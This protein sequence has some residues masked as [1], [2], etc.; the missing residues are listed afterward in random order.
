MKVIGIVGGIASGKS[1]VADELAT[2]GAVL[3]D[4]D[5]MGKRGFDGTRSG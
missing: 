4:A 3:V 1:V 5:Q 2:L